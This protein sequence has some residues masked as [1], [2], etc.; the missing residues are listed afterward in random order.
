MTSRQSRTAS[1]ARRPGRGWRALV[2][3]GLVGSLVGAAG[4]G[5]AVTGGSGVTLDY[6]LWDTVQLPGYRACADAFEAENPGI[7]IRI[8][9]YGWADYWQKLTA[10]LIAGAGPDVFTDHLTKYPEFVTRDVLLPL[11]SLEATSDF[12]GSEFQEGLADLWMGQD[13]MHYGMP[14]DFDTIALFFDH[15]MLE[16]AGMTAADLQDLTWN[17]EDGGTFE[18]VIAHLSVDANGV[19]GD[20][21]G[22]DPANVVTYGLASAGSGGSGHGQTQWSWLAGATGWTYTDEEVWAQEYNY[23][24]PRVQD[25]VAWLFGLVDKGFMPSFEE[26]G[27]SP[28]PTQQLGSGSAALSADGS[29]TIRSYEQLDGIELGIAKVPAGPADHPASM[30]NGL[31]DS[32]SAQTDHPQEAAQFVSFLGSDACQVIIGEEGVIFPARPAGTEAAI[33]TFNER[34]ID[35]TPFT[36]LVENENTVLFPVTDH[37]A[38]VLSILNPVMDGIYIG[39]LDASA[40]TEANEQINDLFEGG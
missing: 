25:S 5:S 24:D 38:E 15:A 33:E 19:R 8:T 11:E 40:L 16:E 10:G 13:G 28:N 37:G 9:Q 12:D 36:E 3:S 32:I 31:G 14:K 29:W 4:C 23:D 18:D 34:G 21:E 20:E 1:P 17:P 2:G 39:D 27:T 7:D 30:Y 6:W 22:F 26:V 35:V